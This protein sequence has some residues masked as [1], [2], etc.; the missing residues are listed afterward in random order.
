MISIIAAIARNG[1]IGGNNNMPW[2]IGEDL[3]HFKAITSGHPVVMGRKTFESLGKALPNRRNIVIT[4]NAGYEAPGAETTTSLEN[5]LS[6]FGPDE[7]VFIIGGGEI[8]RQAMNSAD[9]MYLTHIDADY[10]GDTRFP[11]IET[12]DWEITFSEKHDHGEQFPQPFE[13]VNYERRR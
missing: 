3:K 7:E 8:Y 13:F 4:R 11:E 2:H 10:D 12:E 9:R 6:L 5:A 1:V